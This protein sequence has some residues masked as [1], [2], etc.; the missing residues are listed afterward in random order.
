MKTNQGLNYRCL[1]L[2][3]SGL[4]RVGIA[5]PP[6]PNG[7]IALNGLTSGFDRSDFAVFQEDAG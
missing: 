5:G 2:R 4:G 1:G 6:I 3:R 7:L